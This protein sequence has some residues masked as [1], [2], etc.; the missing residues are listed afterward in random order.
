MTII[1]PKLR[2]A[3]A[4]SSGS[5]THPPS[6]LTS[7]DLSSSV[8]QSHF[9]R[10]S[11]GFENYKMLHNLV[12]QNPFTVCVFS[13]CPSSCWVLGRQWRLWQG[14]CPQGAQR[15]VEKVSVLTGTRHNVPNRMKQAWKSARETS[16]AVKTAR[17][18]TIRKIMIFSMCLKR[19][20]QKINSG[21]W[22]HSQNRV[23]LCLSL[24]WN[25]SQQWPVGWIT[26]ESPG[27]FV[28]RQWLRPTPRVP[29]SAG[30]G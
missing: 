28:T 4:F 30:L 1:F 25:T 18:V 17:S 8:C 15:L 5:V 13:V 12:T 23:K 27:E 21:L 7:L 29:D 2:Q 22:E 10:P 24:L 6:H 3:V 26:A 20:H 11:S 19:I 16:Q 14:S 9:L